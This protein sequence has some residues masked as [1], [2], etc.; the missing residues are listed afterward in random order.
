M[1]LL[2]KACVRYVVGITCSLLVFS[3]KGRCFSVCF[4]VGESVRM[5]R[6]LGVESVSGGRCDS[7]KV[8]YTFLT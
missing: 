7:P 6:F 3:I 4:L 2:E 5:L 1:F 8:L